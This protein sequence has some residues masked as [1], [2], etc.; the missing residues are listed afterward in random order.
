MTTAATDDQRNRLRSRQDR[1]DSAEA[2]RRTLIAFAV[3]AVFM[4]V[5]VA[6]GLMSGSLAL[7][8]DAAHMLA[9]VL[10]LLMAW[11]AF[12]L[13]RL[14]ADS[15]RSYGYR[16]LEV[17]A[18]LANGAT[19]VA[20]SVGIVYEAVLRLAQPSAVQGWPMLA[21]AAIGLVANVATFR[22]LDH[23]HSPG[24]EHDHGHAHDPGHDHIHHDRPCEAGRTPERNLNMRGA[25]LHVLGD[26]LGS[27]AAVAAAAVILATGW[28]P[29]DPI[30]S[31]AMAVLIAISGLRLMASAGHILLEGSPAGFDPGRLTA[32][33][34]DEVGG[35]V[36][37]HHL[38]AWS[39]TSGRHML[40][41]HAVVRQG[42]DHDAAL[43][44]IKHVLSDDFG[45][46]HSV[47]QI[48]GEGCG[49][50]GCD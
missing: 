10:A 18:A 21:V 13:G 9:D 7:L 27:V 1:R 25:V 38:H 33:L 49:D 22:I 46:T 35:L 6:G 39:V 4:V 41:L 19:V 28:I 24:H 11:G 36:D 2:E 47:V 40:T 44:A 14:A 15:K 48:E 12:R 20:L 8:A 5:E 29:I 17:L 32:Q 26:I 31:V 37:I 42:V 23:R 3:T 50:D 30:L 16:R 34:R 43:A 45:F